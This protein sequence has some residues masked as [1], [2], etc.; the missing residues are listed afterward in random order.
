MV[1]HPYNE[2]IF[3]DKKEMSYQTRKRQRNVKCVFQKV[4]TIGRIKRL[5]RLVFPR[6]PRGK[7]GRMNR[8]HMGDL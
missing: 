1:V 8:R 2:I 4:K 6:G 3:S 7:G 5:R